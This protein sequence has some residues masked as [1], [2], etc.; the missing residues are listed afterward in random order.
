MAREA[1]MVSMLVL[2][3]ATRLADLEGIEAGPDF[4]LE[5]LVQLIPPAR[6]EANR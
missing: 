3:G 4:V 5:D 6:V 2:S 1:G